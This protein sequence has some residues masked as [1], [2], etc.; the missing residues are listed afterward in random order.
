MR[1]TINIDDDVLQFARE[2]AAKERRSVGEILS[3]LARRGV[4]SPVSAVSSPIR[5]GIEI[6]PPRGECV[7]LEH[8]QELIDEEAV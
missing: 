8:V 5:N 7:T 3:E 4:R 6:L 2:R 1:T